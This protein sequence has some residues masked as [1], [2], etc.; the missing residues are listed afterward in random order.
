MN[1]NYTLDFHCSI[2]AFSRLWTTPQWA[3]PDFMSRSF[4]SEVLY[5]SRPFLCGHRHKT[6]RGRWGNGGWWGMWV[7]VDP[8]QGLCFKPGKVVHAGKPSRA[9]SLWNPLSLEALMTPSICLQLQP[10]WKHAQPVGLRCLN[11]SVTCIYCFP[12]VGNPMTRSKST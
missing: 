12:W 1:A 4:L 10:T 9:G 2:L 11:D 7:E 5:P 3:C 8:Y 6:G